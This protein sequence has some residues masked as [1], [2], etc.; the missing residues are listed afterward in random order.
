MNPLL[1][2]RLLLQAGCASGLSL[3]GVAARACE[4]SGSTL[5]VTHP[6]TRATT[7]EATT[8]VVCMKFDEVL[9]DE[10]LIGLETP[11]AEGAEMGGLLARPGIDFRIPKGRESYLSES[12]S[13]V[14]L[15]GLVQPLEVGRT[16]PLRLLF[17]NGGALRADLS[18]DYTRFR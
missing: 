13:F 4:F 2:R 12:G 10:R 18:V 1:H 6:W 7:D 15:L 9:Q 16:Y 14:R 5:R 11:I 3:A 17:E 8:A